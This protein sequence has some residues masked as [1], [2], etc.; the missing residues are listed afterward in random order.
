MR[1]TGFLIFMVTGSMAFAA[2]GSG[3]GAPCD[4]RG[5]TYECGRYEVCAQVQGGLHC[6][7]ICDDHRDCARDERC[8]GVKDTDLKACRPDDDYYEDDDGPGPGPG[9]Y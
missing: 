4:D 7:L 1:F 5:E 3:L 2:C 9:P 6:Q 8:G